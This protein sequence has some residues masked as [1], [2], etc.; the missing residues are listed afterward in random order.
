MKIT[1]RF[2][3]AWRAF[4]GD[5]WP[6]ESQPVVYVTSRYHQWYTELV[7]EAPWD[8][9]E[10]HNREL[11]RTKY[12]VLQSLMDNEYIWHID[13][14]P[15]TRPHCRSFNVRLSFWVPE[16]KIKS[17]PNPTSERK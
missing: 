13:E 9:P 12:E 10:Y 14:R 11:K 1:Q 16:N 2:K 3:N 8:K 6:Y 4:K 17:K 7:F 15:A 5:V